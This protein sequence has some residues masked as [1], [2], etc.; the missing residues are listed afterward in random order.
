MLFNKVYYIFF[1]NWQFCIWWTAPDGNNDKYYEM[2]L[3][4]KYTCK[5]DIIK[6][7]RDWGWVDMKTK[8]STWNKD[9]LL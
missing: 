4:W 8:L 9:Y 2:I 5:K 6:A 7:E 3:H 1:F